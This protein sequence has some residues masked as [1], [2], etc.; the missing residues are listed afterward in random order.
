MAQQ[1][2][3]QT[4][5]SKQLNRLMYLCIIHIIMSVVLTSFSKFPWNHKSPKEENIIHFIPFPISRRTDDKLFNIISLADILEAEIENLWLLHV[6]TK[7]TKEKEREKLKNLYEIR[8]TLQNDV[9]ICASLTQFLSLFIYFYVPP[10][11]ASV[12][13]WC[14]T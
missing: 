4:E 8:K 13:K 6:E 5:F 9:N 11:F 10:S 1:W 3:K 14:C 7:Q 2:R 12:W